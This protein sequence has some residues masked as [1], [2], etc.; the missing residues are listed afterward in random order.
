MW[1]GERTSY[2]DL[3]MAGRIAF[4]EFIEVGSECALVPADRE[5]LAIVKRICWREAVGRHRIGVIEKT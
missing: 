3:R 5:F 1:R 4:V 2:P